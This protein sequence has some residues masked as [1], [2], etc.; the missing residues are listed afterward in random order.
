[1]TRFLFQNVPPSVTFMENMGGAGSGSDIDSH[2]PNELKPVLSEFCSFE[3]F[4]D[5]GLSGSWAVARSKAVNRS[6][7]LAFATSRTSCNP[8]DTRSPLRVGLVLDC[9]MFSL[10]RTLPGLRG[11]QVLFV[12]L[13]HRY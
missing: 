1:M 2:R 9:T 6:L 7:L 12:R 11:K 3:L 10:A 8:W 13:V 5:H 4:V